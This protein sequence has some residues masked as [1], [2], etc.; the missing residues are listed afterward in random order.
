MY[1]SSGH[2]NIFL[3]A[4]ADPGGRFLGYDGGQR[5]GGH[6]QHRL[7]HHVRRLQGSSG[8]RLLGSPT[9]LRLTVASV[10]KR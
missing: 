1:F 4:S 9:I 8:A 3:Q 2:Q 10:E 6:H 7:A 5:R